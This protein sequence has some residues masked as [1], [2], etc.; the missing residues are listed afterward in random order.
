MS[1]LIFWCLPDLEHAGRLMPVAKH[2]K[3]KAAKAE[4]KTQN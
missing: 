3:E 1:C 4:K 2:W